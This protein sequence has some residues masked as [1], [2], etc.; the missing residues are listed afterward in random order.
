[1]DYILS[2]HENWQNTDETD[3]AP[4]VFSVRQTFEAL[5]AFVHEYTRTSFE[6]ETTTPA[7]EMDIEG[8]KI[9]IARC[10]LTPGPKE[11]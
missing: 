5:S 4:R 8:K 3:I 1:V 7:S 6:E 2:V 11:V 9:V 10:T